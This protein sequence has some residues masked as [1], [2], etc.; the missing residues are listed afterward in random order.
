MTIFKFNQQITRTF[1]ES[2]IINLSLQTQMNTNRTGVAPTV[3]RTSVS[4]SPRFFPSL[5]HSQHKYIYNIAPSYL[6][7]PNKAWDPKSGT[8]NDI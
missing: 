3:A 6:H 5:Q 7:L 4:P 2:G 8:Q 1:S